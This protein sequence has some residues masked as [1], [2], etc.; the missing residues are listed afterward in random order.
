MTNPLLKRFFEMCCRH[1]FSWPH[2]GLHGQD[3]QVCLICGVAYEYDCSTMQRTGRLAASEDAREM[4]ERQT[5][6]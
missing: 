4:P 2:A 5:F 3:Y 1:R 6:K